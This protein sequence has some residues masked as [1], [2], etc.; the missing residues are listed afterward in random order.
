MQIW[1]QSSGMRE[2]CLC[3]HSWDVYCPLALSYSSGLCPSPAQ[4]TLKRRDGNSRSKYTNSWD[5]HIKLIAWGSPA[6]WPRNSVVWVWVK[7]FLPFIR[8]LNWDLGNPT[9]EAKQE[10]T[11][12]W[13]LC[14]AYIW[15]WLEVSEDIL[16][17]EGS[18]GAGRV[19][20]HSNR[21][22]EEDKNGESKGTLRYRTASSTECWRKW[23]APPSG[24][25]RCLRDHVIQKEAQ[26][27]SWTNWEKFKE[28]EASHFFSRSWARR[29]CH[30][31]VI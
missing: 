4:W 22:I 3:E 17:H 7:N 20:H 18:D 9:Q 28:P 11:A 24:Q 19:Q 5:H 12:A 1:I 15:S 31:A 8:M 10:V 23:T 27:I 14:L 16:Y 25:V 30:V 13:L 21:K 2:E 26:E 6:L 29:Y